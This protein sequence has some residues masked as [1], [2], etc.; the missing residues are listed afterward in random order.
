MSG[1]EKSDNCTPSAPPEGNS[2]SSNIVGQSTSPVLYQQPSVQ[3][4]LLGPEPPVSCCMELPPYSEPPPSY[5]A[6]MAYPVPSGP[7]STNTDDTTFP[8]P[9]SAVPSYHL[10]SV[11]NQIFPPASPPPLPSVSTQPS[12]VALP[13]AGHC[14]YCRVGVVSSQTDLFCLICLVLLAVCTFPV[15]LLFLCFIP[16]TIHKRCSHCRRIG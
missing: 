14:A 10:L 6:A 16:C 12:P 2:F 5:Q 9:Y 4:L 7:Y 8:K 11:P 15:G 1:K 13:R 3:P